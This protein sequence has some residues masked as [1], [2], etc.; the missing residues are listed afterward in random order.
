MSD[1]LYIYHDKIL[2]IK[3]PMS[4]R[5]YNVRCDLLTA[6]SSPKNT[7]TPSRGMM[8]HINNGRYKIIGNMFK[9]GVTLDISNATLMQVYTSRM[10]WDINIY[11]TVKR[12]NSN[13]F[14]IIP[15]SK[16]SAYCWRIP[17][18]IHDS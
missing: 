14:I 13:P 18:S 10:L 7:T 3:C 8:Y 9:M 15:S 4:E 11:K 2:D 1:A 6:F 16:S 12:P 5:L 17:V